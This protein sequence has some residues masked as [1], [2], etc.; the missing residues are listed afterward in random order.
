MAEVDECCEAG[1]WVGEGL[2]EGAGGVGGSG[3]R[4]AAGPGEGDSGL[5][6]L[7]W[8]EGEYSYTEYE[9]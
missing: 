8:Q 6:V 4:A 3:Q 7:Q 5:D 9:I 1:A 2:G